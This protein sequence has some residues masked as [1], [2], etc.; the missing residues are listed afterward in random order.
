MDVHP[1]HEPVHTW[2]DALV[3][4]GIV[5][6]G[7]FIALSL[8]AIVEY[9]HHRNLVHEARENIRTELQQNRQALGHDIAFMGQNAGRLDADLKTMRYLQKHTDAHNQSIQFELQYE[10]LNDTA[11]HT[12]RDTGALG[13]MPY[14]E[15]QKY[16]EAYAMQELLTQRESDL[17]VHEDEDFAVIAAHDADF[18]AI[19]PAD[20]CGDAASHSSLT[21]E[22]A[23]AAAACSRLG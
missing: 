6:V 8:E 7:L 12:A 2:R 15:V 16:A 13:Y 3:H 10:S 11:W 18:N 20:V 19:S 14:K 17:V 5:T 4:L 22:C 9:V 23:S 1:P 21:A